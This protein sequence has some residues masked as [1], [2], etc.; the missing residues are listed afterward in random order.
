MAV[1]Y[2]KCVKKFALKQLFHYETVN[3]KFDWPADCSYIIVVRTIMKILAL[4]ILLL[5]HF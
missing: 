5:F 3:A 2:L 4:I 1:Q